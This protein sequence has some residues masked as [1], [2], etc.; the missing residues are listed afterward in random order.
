[1]T[2]KNSVLISVITRNSIHAQT[3]RWLLDQP[4]PVDI[5][6]SPYTIE[7]QRNWQVERFLDRSE[8]YLFILDDDT[9]PKRGTIEELLRFSDEERTIL[10]A[11]SFG[12]SSDGQHS[13]IMAYNREEDGS[14]FYPVPPVGGILKVDFAGMSGALLPRQVFSDVISPWFYMPHENGKLKTTEDVYFWDRVYDAGW[15]LKAHL[16]LVAD[17]LKL[18][19]LSTLPPK[20]FDIPATSC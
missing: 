4:Y 7:H 17:H 3:V 5:I 13:I 20:V 9:V 15:T 6:Q 10:V 16:G 19:A 8:D 14:L 18:V 1:M 12:F 2:N 11:P